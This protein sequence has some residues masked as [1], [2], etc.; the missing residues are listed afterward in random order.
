MGEEIQPVHQSTHTGNYFTFLYEKDVPMF[1]EDMII[2]SLMLCTAISIKN[3]GVMFVLMIVFYCAKHVKI[4]S[5]HPF[6][7]VHKIM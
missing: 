7:L 1:Q 5:G 4:L 2:S 3:K 6:F